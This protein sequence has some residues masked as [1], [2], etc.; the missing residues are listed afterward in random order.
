MNPLRIISL[1][2]LSLAGLGACSLN[3]SPPFPAVVSPAPPEPEYRTTI[4]PRSIVHTVLIPAQSAYV[5]TSAVS[6]GL[7]TVEAFAHKSAAIA[8]LNAGF[9]DPVNQQTTSH[10]VVNGKLAADPRQNDRLINNPDLTKYLDQILNRSEFRTYRCGT[11][12]RY[13][14]T[15]HTAPTPKSCQLIAAIGAGPQLLPDST[16]AAEG[17]VDI[18]SGR[19]ALG[20]T[21]PNARA[22][23]G[24]TA[25]GMCCGQWWRKNPTPQDQPG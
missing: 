24:L 25:A 16:A 21:Q 18:A 17:F 5:V 11:V 20:S 19:D 2:L 10:V 12:T 4:L 13:D 8:A 9:F 14:I 23:I 7:E 3:A 22:A 6:D 1:G 15:P